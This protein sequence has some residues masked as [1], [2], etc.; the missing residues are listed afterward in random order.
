MAQRLSGDL[1]SKLAVAKITEDLYSDPQLRANFVADPV[2]TVKS[3]YGQDVT[4]GD[5]EQR[6]LTEL[7]RM[8]ADGNCC[9]GCG[10]S[11]GGGFGRVVNP[12]LR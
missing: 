1:A 3:V 10:C 12:V 6:F 9:S 5:P 2:G 8:I 11:G 7:Q 4:V